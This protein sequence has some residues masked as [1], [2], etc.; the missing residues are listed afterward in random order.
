MVPSYGHSKEALINIV[1]ISTCKRAFNKHTQKTFYAC[2][3]YAVRIMHQ[4]SFTFQAPVDDG[5]MLDCD[6]WSV[7]HNWN[8]LQN[9]GDMLTI[10]EHC[11]RIIKRML[12]PHDAHPNI[13]KARWNGDG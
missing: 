8:G 3:T 13:L 10:I 7:A 4:H 1:I 6:L 2:A 9:S 12:A 11:I 5:D